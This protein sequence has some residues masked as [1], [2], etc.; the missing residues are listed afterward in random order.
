MITDCFGSGN[1]LLALDEFVFFEDAVEL[2]L[3]AVPAIIGFILWRIFIT[4]KVGPRAGITFLGLDDSSSIYSELGQ[5]RLNHYLRFEYVIVAV[6]TFVLGV[7]TSEVWK[8][9]FVMFIA[10]AE[11]ELLRY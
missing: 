3:L 8:S 2:H 1:G 11:T 6:L 5:C 4:N 9:L 10:P 7:L